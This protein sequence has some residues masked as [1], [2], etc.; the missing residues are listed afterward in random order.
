M[1]RRGR[2]E[3]G[4]APVLAQSCIHTS[5]FKT[6]YFL[7]IFKSMQQ[8]VNT[9][10]SKHC[11]QTLDFLSWFISYLLLSFTR[12]REIKTHIYIDAIHLAVQNNTVENTFRSTCARIFRFCVCLFPKYFVERGAFV[13][14]CS[15]CVR[16][17]GI[18]CDCDCSL[19]H[20]FFFGGV[21]L[22]CPGYVPYTYRP[23]MCIQLS[24]GCCRTAVVFYLSLSFL[25][26]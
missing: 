10:Q 11:Q 1:L 23:S 17:F 2:D 16:T 18:T 4:V 19:Y 9:R 24:Q 14:V 26:D 13:S 7:K 6:R 21:P 12:C 25:L 3:V 22:F 8:R 20:N 5:P 15:W